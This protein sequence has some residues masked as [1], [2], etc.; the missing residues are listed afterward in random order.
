MRALTIPVPDRSELQKTM[1]ALALIPQPYARITN[2]WQ[3]AMKGLIGLRP[4]LG[5]HNIAN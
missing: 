4:Q 5:L 1:N 3:K 2:M